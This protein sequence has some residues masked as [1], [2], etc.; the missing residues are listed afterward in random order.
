MGRSDSEATGTSARDASVGRESGDGGRATRRERPRSDVDGEGA[1]GVERVQRGGDDLPLD[2]ADLEHWLTEW[3]LLSG[4]RLYV[5]ALGAAV[6]FVVVALLELAGAVSLAETSA[7]VAVFGGFLGGNLTLVTVVVSI[8]QLLL[9][10][11]F[12]GPGELRTQLDNVIEYREGVEASA[13]RVAPVEPFTFLQ[14]LF[15]NTRQEA[16][17]LGGL[18]FNGTPPDARRDI[19]SLVTSITTHIDLIDSLLDRAGTS[20]FDVLSVTLSTNYA[21]QINRIRHVRSD[22]GDELSE[23]VMDSLEQLCERFQDIDI[24]RQ[25]FKSVYLQEELS[26][27]SRT[28]LFVGGLAELVAVVLLL[29]FTGPLGST[30]PQPALLATLPVAVA[31]CFLPLSV[32]TSVILRSATVTRRTAITLPFATPEE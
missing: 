4:S 29:V 22:Y 10:R 20:T 12:K 11:E 32:L 16:Q 24:A 1:D 9:S 7:L 14:L 31:I 3:V 21:R 18:T 6:A 19:D 27:L 30:I 15:D 25:Y 5:G 26:A 2:P 23:P 17:Q 28:L 8:N 13:G